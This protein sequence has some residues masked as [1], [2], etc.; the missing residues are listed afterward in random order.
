M[1]HQRWSSKK[2]SGNQ[3]LSENEHRLLVRNSNFGGAVFCRIAQEQCC[4]AAKEMHLC[5]NGVIMALGQGP[6]EVP[7]FEG[8]PWEAKLS[9][10]VV[11]PPCQHLCICFL[12]EVNHS[13]P[14]YRYAATAVRLAWWPHV[15]PP[16]A[17]STTCS[18]TASVRTR[19]KHAA[20]TRPRKT[21][22][23][24]SLLFSPD[25]WRCFSPTYFAIKILPI[26]F[27]SQ[28]LFWHSRRS[29]SQ[30]LL[31]LT[32]QVWLYFDCF[33]SW[34]TWYLLSSHRNLPLSVLAAWWIFWF[35]FY[36]CVF[37]LAL[38]PFLHR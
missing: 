27:F 1:S 25:F 17:T 32:A 24:G 2:K 6:C 21:R 19:L 9:K 12:L 22:E 15:T 37:R 16:A 23:L 11:H 13:A 26:I 7:F 20:S 35:V 3:N 4:S 14:P 28:T 8:E 29:T 5:L 31:Q 33:K 18:W 10:V 30:L 34:S 38:F 36:L